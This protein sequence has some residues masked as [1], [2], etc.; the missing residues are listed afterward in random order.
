MRKQKETN[1]LNYQLWNAF[2]RDPQNDDWYI[3]PLLILGALVAFIAFAGVENV[4]NVLGQV[5]AN[6]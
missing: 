3:V 6:W 5:V 1:H 2:K 4:F